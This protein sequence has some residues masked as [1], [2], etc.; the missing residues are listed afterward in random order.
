MTA[1]TAR[2]QLGLC[3]ER[4]A[5]Y[6]WQTIRLCASLSLDHSQSIVRLTLTGFKVA[7]LQVMCAQFRNT[8]CHTQ[9]HS[10]CCC[11]GRGF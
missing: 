8:P 9:P 11:P 3:F 7:A 6:Q 1:V 10:D 5:W 2:A 4:C